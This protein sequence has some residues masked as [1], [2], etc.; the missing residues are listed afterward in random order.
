MNLENL[1]S[2]ISW[3]TQQ[4]LLF[5]RTVAENIDFGLSFPSEKER[6]FRIQEAAK[7]AQVHEFI[8][9]L[10]EAYGNM[11][12]D[13]GT[14][15]SGG[16][17]QRISLARCLLRDTPIVILGSLLVLGCSNLAQMSTLPHWITRMKPKSLMLWK[18]SLKTKR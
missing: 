2:N 7:N 6:H 14:Q 11:V 9:G 5:N 17:R 4:P 15:L 10:P 13:R 1:R 8:V 12:G 3:V 16:E 18:D